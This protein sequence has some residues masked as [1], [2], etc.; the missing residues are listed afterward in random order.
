[1]L[2]LV[3][4]AAIALSASLSIGS[5]AEAASTRVVVIEKDMHHPRMD[6]R[7]RMDRRAHM[8]RRSNRDHGC[9]TKKVVK[10]VHGE[11]VVKMTK[12]CR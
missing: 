3:M 8:D 11:R 9:M 6:R 10:R 2:K 5:V 4:A 7:D 12:V 1:M